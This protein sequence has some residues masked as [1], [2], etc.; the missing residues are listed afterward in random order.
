MRDPLK[1][2]LHFVGIRQSAPTVKKKKHIRSRL[3]S[4]RRYLE[5][6]LLLDMGSIATD[7]WLYCKYE[8]WDYLKVAL[9]YT[10]C[11]ECIDYFSH[12]QSDRLRSLLCHWVQKDECMISAELDMN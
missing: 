10:G 9:L 5:A 4:K 1:D 2:P 11:R 12:S 3:Y 8:S 7:S 6:H